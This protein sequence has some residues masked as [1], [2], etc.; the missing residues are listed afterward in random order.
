MTRH[1]PKF[2]SALAAYDA[3]DLERALKLMEECAAEGDPKAC[4]LAASWHRDSEFPSATPKRSDEWL[5]RFVQLAEEGNVEAQWDVGQSFRFGDL[6]PLDIEQA[7]DWLERAAEGGSG[8]A[9]HHLAWFYEHGL[10][11]YPIDRKKSE[12]WYERALKQEHPETLYL[13]AIK[14]FTDGQPTK[15]ALEFLHKAADKGFK[16]AKDNLN[17]FLH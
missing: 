17:R 6:L 3:N 13:Y 4:A 12:E 5:A 14:M 2:Q 9:Q 8:D 11:G 10:Y 7:N 16:Q 1:S 15:E